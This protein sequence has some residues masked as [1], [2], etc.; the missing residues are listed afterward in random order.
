M[1]TPWLWAVFTVIAAFAQTLRNAMQ[2]ELTTSLGTVGATHVRFLFGLPF[3]LI[4]LIG[5]L[6][7]DPRG[8][9]K[10]GADFLALGDR[11]RL[12]AGRRHRADARCHG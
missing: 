3:V 9:A 10:A 8:A 4:F 2:R 7:R 5:E 11:W 12:R 1:A 6:D